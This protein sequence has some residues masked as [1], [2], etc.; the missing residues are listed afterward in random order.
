MATPAL[1]A[2]RTRFRQSH[3]TYL[4]R[5]YIG[6]LLA[7]CP[8]FDAVE[9]WP[10]GRAGRLS[11]HL[12]LVKRLR[13]GKFDLAILFPNSFRSA[14][15]A[16]LAGADERVGFARDGRGWLLTRRLTPKRDG[17][18]FVAVPMV[19]YY[20]ELVAAVDCPV[21]D[22]SLE[23]CA[24]PEDEQRLDARLGHDDERPIAVLNP[25]AAYGSAKCWPAERYAEVADLLALRHG[26][27]VIVTCGPS[28]RAIA[29]ALKSAA[30]RALEVFVDP[31]LGLG[32]LKALI[33][34]AKVM[35]TND[36]GPRHFAAAFN[37]PVVTIFGSSDPAWTETSHALERKVSVA[38]DCQPCMQR[39]CP[40]GHHN[41]M[42]HVSVE[43]VMSAVGELL[44]VSGGVAGSERHANSRSSLAP[45]YVQDAR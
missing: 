27:R 7:G 34:R 36:T 17:R 41:C 22:P 9:R 3:I 2:I 38:L 24:T 13:H 37:T 29:H 39:I 23:L 25:G 12:R 43:M 19:D 5:P 15:I 33:R 40:L 14:M 21:E 16:R 30:R 8:W 4:Q 18:C 26:M 42:K 20:R 6:E 35:I 45:A 44:E 10:E 1:R 31:P 32:P 28:E 11:S